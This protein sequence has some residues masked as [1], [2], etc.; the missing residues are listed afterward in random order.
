MSGELK[1]MKTLPSEETMLLKID[2]KQIL[3]GD[4]LIRIFHKTTMKSNIICRISFNSSM[5]T[6]ELFSL[7]IRQLDPCSIKK[8]KNISKNISVDVYTSP[9][10]KVC[11]N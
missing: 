10:C 9:Y 8:N 2:H 3:N 11:T 6:E 7:D 5:L 1:K 4:I